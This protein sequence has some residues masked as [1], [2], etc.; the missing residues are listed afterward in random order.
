MKKLLLLLSLSLAL[1]ADKVEPKDNRFGK[2]TVV[3][4]ETEHY[5][6]LCIRG[7]EYILDL[8]G[9]ITQSFE[10][11]YY[12]PAPVQVPTQCKGK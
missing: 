8:Q 3:I 5:T 12:N 1:F 6:V 11:D 9:S 2:Y 10:K 7:Y 4:E